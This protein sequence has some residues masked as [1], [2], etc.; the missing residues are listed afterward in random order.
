MLRQDQKYE[1]WLQIIQVFYRYLRSDA[2]IFKRF[3][4]QALSLRAIRVKKNL[5]IA[6][7][8]DQAASTRH[9]IFGG[10]YM[11][12]LRFCAMILRYHG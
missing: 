3:K 5:S 7:Q 11:M 9:A 10:E 4:G 8:R 1:V 6:K 2:K 12:A